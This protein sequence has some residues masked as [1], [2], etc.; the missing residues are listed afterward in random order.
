[1]RAFTY[2][3][4]LTLTLA[5]AAFM[6]I[7]SNTQAATI[8]FD[9]SDHNGWTTS[10]WWM[11]TQTSNVYQGT[12]ALTTSNGQVTFKHAGFSPGSGSDGIWTLYVNTTSNVGLTG[13]MV[14]VNGTD[15]R[16][17][18]VYVVDDVSNGGGYFSIDADSSTWQ[19]VQWDSSQWSTTTAITTLDIRQ[20]WTG[21]GD[22][23]NVI[24]DYAFFGVIPEP[25]SLLLLSLGAG[26]VL[27]RTR[28]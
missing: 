25:G 8:L 7:A 28:R 23:E 10:D 11:G 4:L 22:P 27:L 18:D 15:Q 5:L 14:T 16:T 3:Y 13:M 12:T 20:H 1:M 21:S 9:D 6:G 17:A 24:G 26:C 19:K 2:P